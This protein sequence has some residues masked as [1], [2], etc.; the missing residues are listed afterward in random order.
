MAL[1][2]A[3][4]HWSRHAAQWP[5]IGPPLRPTP[6]D[7][8]TARLA[9]ADWLRGR[10][11]GGAFALVLGV[12]PELC[13]LTLD[14]I[15]RLIAVDR[16][17]AMIRHTWPGPV[18]AM[19]GAL[20]AD[21]RRLPL[22]DASVDV[23]LGD[24]ALNALPTLDEYQALGRE[25]AR[26]LRPDGRCVLRCFVQPPVRESVDEV[27]AA[28][29]RGEVG[30]FHALKWRVA[31]ALQRD[32]ASGVSVGEVWEVVHRAWHDLDALAARFTWPVQEVRTIDAYRSIDTRYTFP[33][34]DECRASLA[35][36]GF[37]SIRSTIGAYELA[38]RCPTFVGD[39]RA[40]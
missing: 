8:A 20:C 23:V 35:S 18:R 4:D 33:A 15:G 9:V 6:D 12:T 24:G 34:F 32:T 40:S 28:L 37:T 27:I 36:W 19:D 30:S 13:T 17:A 21:W 26:V 1:T 2:A 7:I 10:Q 16:S 3:V 14:G 31:M 22:A 11:Q 39:R 29:E 5:A 25:L 38:D